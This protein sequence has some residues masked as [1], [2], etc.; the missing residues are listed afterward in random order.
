MD[1]IIVGYLVLILRKAGLNMQEIAKLNL[2]SLLRSV[3]AVEA[4][5]LGKLYK[6]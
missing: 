6:R 2:D 1:N 4:Q 5:M 3:S